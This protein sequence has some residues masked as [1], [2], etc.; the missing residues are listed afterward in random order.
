MKLF[1]GLG[2]PGE[3]Y[4]RNRHNVGYMAVDE[5]AASNGFSQWRSKF[6]G[7]TS[8]GRLG[9]EKII[10]L[11]P[12]TYMNLSGN[13]VAKAARF[14]KLEAPSITVFHDELDLTP[15][16][17]R[18]KAGGG[19]AGHNGLRSIHQHMGPD[20]GRVRIGIGHPGDKSRVSAYV[21]HDFTKADENWLAPLLTGI[22]RNAAALANGDGAQFLNGVALEMNPRHSAGARPRKTATEPPPKPQTAPEQAPQRTPLQRLVDKFR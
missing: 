18:L 20:Y 8:E 22:A 10:L 11:K 16:K 21:L 3:K 7:Q 15:G 6:D 19:H 13:A 14:Y 1:V 12:E 2:N 17:I 9:H 5:I 4:A